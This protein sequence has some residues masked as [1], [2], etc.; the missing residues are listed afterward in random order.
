M[1]RWWRQRI[2]WGDI[3]VEVGPAG[4]RAIS[5]PTT[6]VDE[7]V[8]RPRCDRGIAGQLDEYFAGRRMTFSIAVDLP[9]TLSELQRRILLT[10]RDV[11]YGETV[12]Y[13]EVAD[14]VGRP[15]AARAVGSTMAKNP[16]PFLIPCHR[17]VAANGIGGYGG[18]YGDGVA[19]KRALLDLEAGGRPTR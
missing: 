4:V 13:G 11:P 2:P 1:T 17:V 16:V 15:R 10:V 8:S 18:G 9:S 7:Y 6:P 5:L 3:V 12:T 14:M 19:F